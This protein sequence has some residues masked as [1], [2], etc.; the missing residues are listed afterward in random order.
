M[1]PRR[2]RP[3]ALLPRLLP[4]LLGLALA[5]PAAARELTVTGFGGG[6]QD[7]ARKH[8]F[9]DFTRATGIPLRDDVYNGELAKIYAMVQARS[10]A[11]DVV[12]VEAPELQRGCEDGVFARIDWSV[13]NR[14]KF[15]PGGAVTCG[16]GAVGWGVSLF[17]DRA[18]QAQGPA[19][20]VELWDLQRFPGKRSL[21]FGPK[22]TLEIALL[23]DGVAANQIY[24]LLATPQGQDR[25][26]ASL[27]RIKPQ[28]LWWRSGTQP[29]QFVGSGEAAYAVGYVGR[30]ARAAEQGADYPLQWNTLLYSYDYW[31]VVRGSENADQGMRLIEHITEAGP[32]RAMSADWAISPANAAVARDPELLRRQPAMVAAHAEKGLFIDTDFWVEHG[33]DLEARFAAWAAR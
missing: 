2:F 5:A 8:L 22:M 11:W 20:Y 1:T 28:I 32:L 10:I 17:W 23:A 14:Q 15:L 3:L 12:M 24:E 31:A 9:A 16:A 4:V 27:D 19:N 25:A 13:V 29:L 18:R 30:T 26:F 21:R 33:A 7:N 6:F